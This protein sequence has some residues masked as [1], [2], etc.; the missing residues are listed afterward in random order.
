MAHTK[1]PSFDKHTELQEDK[2]PGKFLLFQHSPPSLRY[3]V[4]PM[5][6]LRLWKTWRRVHMH[7]LAH[8]V[9]QHIGH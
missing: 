9:A 2:V 8:Q 5:Q 3:F 4:M 1:H 7:V 6:R